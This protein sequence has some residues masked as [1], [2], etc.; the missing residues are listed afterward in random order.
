D[1]LNALQHF[2]TG[3]AAAREASFINYEALGNELAGK[4]C[5]QFNLRR[6]A[7]GYL[8]LAHQNY[9]SWGALVKVRQLEKKGEKLTKKDIEEI[10]RPIIEEYEAQSTP[11]YS[12]ARIWDDGIIEPP[13]TRTALALG[14][15]MSLNREI[16]EQKYGI[17]RM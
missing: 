2:D 7:V 16:P 11:Y 3:I 4:L 1:H 9:R 6:A 14:I 5:V 8:S 13:D 12:T 10:R 17:F 15:A